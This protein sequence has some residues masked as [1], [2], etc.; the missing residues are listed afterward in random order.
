MTIRLS[1][2]NCIL[3]GTPQLLSVNQ[4]MNCHLSVTFLLFNGTM[5][6][7]SSVQSQWNSAEEGNFYQV[8]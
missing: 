2:V 4:A 6:E 7:T 5:I 1:V 8:A 3:T